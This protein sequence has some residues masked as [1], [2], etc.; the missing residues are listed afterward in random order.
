MV[1]SEVYNTV[2]SSAKARLFS[3]VYSTTWSSFCM[4]FQYSIFG[5]PY[6]ESN[7][8]NI[9]G[10]NVYVSDYLNPASADLLLLT[11]SGPQQFKRWHYTNVQISNLAGIQF[12]VNLIFLISRNFSLFNKEHLLFYS[13]TFYLYY[14]FY[15]YS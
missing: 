13:K 5:D 8:S 14:L 10:L 9:D 6:Q 11:V 15:L 7:Q 1:T 4:S 2:A 12:Q 3:P